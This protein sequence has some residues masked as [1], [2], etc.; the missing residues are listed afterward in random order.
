ME[1]CYLEEKMKQSENAKKYNKAI[2]LFS[3]DNS[4]ETKKEA[5]ELFLETA[6]NGYVPSMDAMAY[7]CHENMGDLQTQDREQECFWFEQ[8]VKNLK[9]NRLFYHAQNMMYGSYDKSFPNQEINEMLGIAAGLG[10]D[11][12]AE[13]L[14][15]YYSKDLEDK[16]AL[17]KSLFWFYSLKDP[18]PEVEKRL[19]KVE[20]VLGLR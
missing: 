14:A 6:V 9:G 15:A 20:S 5:I 10:S 16:E 2:Q 1:I 3:E 7:I 19:A 4:D 12:G 17:K 8:A 11:R 18:S 13:S